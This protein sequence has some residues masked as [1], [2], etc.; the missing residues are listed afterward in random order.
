MEEI[1]SFEYETYISRLKNEGSHTDLKE[2]EQY[3]SLQ[4][5][6]SET[7][8][9]NFSSS[10]AEPGE[11]NSEIRFSSYENLLSE[12]EVQ[13]TTSNIPITEEATVFPSKNYE[14]K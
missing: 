10:A 9:D 13:D 5:L 11:Q 14:K 4:N 6:S 12:S 3:S 8:F 2:N 7:D 1:N